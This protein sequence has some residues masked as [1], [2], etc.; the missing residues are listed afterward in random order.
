MK[1]ERYIL[2]Q[3]TPTNPTEMIANDVVAG[4]IQVSTQL[5]IRA[6]IPS[7]IGK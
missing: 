7:A 4:I 2:L 6:W 5:I 1:I 3:E